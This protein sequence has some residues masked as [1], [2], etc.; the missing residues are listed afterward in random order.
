MF[1]TQQSKAGWLV[2]FPL[3]FSRLPSG[4]LHFYGTYSLLPLFSIL[5]IAVYVV[6][7]KRCLR[8]VTTVFEP[9]EEA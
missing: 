1:K 9:I 2:P 5:A 4:L 3:F 8:Q 6:L 7:V